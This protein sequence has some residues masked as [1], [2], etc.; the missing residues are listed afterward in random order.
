MK[1]TG[2]NG[3]VDEFNVHYRDMD[4]RNI[5]KTMSTIHDYLMPKYG[6]K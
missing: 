6:I 3:Y 1:K 2:L 5:G 4:E